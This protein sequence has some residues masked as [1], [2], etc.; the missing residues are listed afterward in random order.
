MHS[1]AMVKAPLRLKFRLV[2][3]GLFRVRCG[4]VLAFSEK[5]RFRIWK[6]PCRAWDREK[7]GR[8]AFDPG[9]VKTSKRK[10]PLE[11]C[12]GV[13]RIARADCGAIA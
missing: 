11:F 13:R 5:S 1:F 12:S 4:I 10:W 8:S 9:R 3:E 7:T 2:A 6:P